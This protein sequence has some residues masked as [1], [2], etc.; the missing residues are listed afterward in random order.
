MSEPPNS[1][2][3]DLES[4][5]G[6]STGPLPRASIATMLAVNGVKVDHNL[7]HNTPT[8]QTACS[9]EIYDI[10]AQGHGVIASFEPATKFLVPLKNDD[11]SPKL[12]LTLQ[13]TAT[14]LRLTIDPTVDKDGIRLSQNETRP[15]TPALPEKTPAAFVKLNE[16]S[17][18]G[19]TLDVILQNNPEIQDAFD[20]YLRQTIKPAETGNSLITP[21]T[22]A[23]AG[24]GLAQT[25]GLGG[26]MLVNV[27]GI[28]S[29]KDVVSDFAEGRTASGLVNLINAIPGYGA[30]A[31]EIAQIAANKM[32]YNV[33]P[34]ASQIV[35]DAAG[36]TNAIGPAQQFNLISVCGNKARPEPALTAEVPPVDTAAL[37]QALYQ[38]GPSP[39]PTATPQTRL[40]PQKLAP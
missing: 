38:E 27:M 39:T 18:S 11:G 16:L 3:V 17:R 25:L 29:L 4:D 33:D 7:H 1:E 12:V 13:D 14:N 5:E 40:Q 2:P 35:A 32:G 26:K 30:I 9:N 37:S 21:Q 8:R 28:V 6:Q 36:L 23:G 19:Q 31:G 20:T 24:A 10:L 22:T 34:S 15:H